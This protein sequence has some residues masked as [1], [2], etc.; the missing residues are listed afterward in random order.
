M[1]HHNNTV[2]II[3]GPTASGKTAL[4]IKLAQRFNTSIISADSRQCFKELNIG[5]AK[6]SERELSMV[7]HYFISSHSI[8]ENVT[9][10]TFERYAL[11]AAAEIFRN[12]NVAIMAGGTGLYIKAFCEGLDIIPEADEKIRLQ[13][14]NNY[15]ING[16]AWLQKQ[17]QIHDPDFWQIAERQNPQRLMRAL[18]VK[19]TTG[20]SIVDFHKG[21]KKV[22]PFN[23]IKLGIEISKEQLHKNINQR[24]TE[25]FE[26]GLIQE[27]T[28]LKAFRNMN[29]LQT[30]GYKELFEYFDTK[31]LLDTTIEKVKIN[32]RHYAKR[33]ITWFKKDPNIKWGNS[34]TLLTDINDY[35]ASGIKN[36][37]S[38][39]PNISIL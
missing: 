21:E 3:T 35:L 32:T 9:A 22:R 1:S 30:V 31:L 28:S 18:E 5:V 38:I 39:T 7:K 19:F 16:I 25:M 15:K 2:I 20:K 14:I 8:H 36:E 29:A 23:I 34:Y 26:Q 4:A 13:V 10:Q 11:D 24:T 12:N 6:P 37:N 27:V 33:Q 17:I